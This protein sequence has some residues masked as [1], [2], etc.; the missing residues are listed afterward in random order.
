MHSFLGGKEKGVKGA[1]RGLKK[2]SWEVFLEGI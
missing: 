1:Y 2:S